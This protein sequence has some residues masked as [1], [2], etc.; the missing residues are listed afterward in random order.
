MPQSRVV[1][2]R[3]DRG[4]QQV[5]PLPQKTRNPRPS[6]IQSRSQE[7]RTVFQNDSWGLSIFSKL[8]FLPPSFT[9]Q[10]R[11]QAECYGLGGG[12]GVQS[13]QVP[14]SWPCKLKAETIFWKLRLSICRRQAFLKKKKFISKALK[15][16]LLIARNKAMESIKWSGHVAELGRVCRRA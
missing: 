8:F 10:T 7:S 12:Y 11:P 9:I 14:N 3:D 15:A 4:D 16:W 13:T 6:L 1:T 5:Q 2:A